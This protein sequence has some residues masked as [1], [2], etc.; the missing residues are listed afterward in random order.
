MPMSTAAREAFRR[1]IEE[2]P[3]S[4][5]L[6]PSPKSTRQQTTHNKFAEGMGGHVEEGWCSVLGTLRTAAHVRN[7]VERRGRCRSHGGADVEAG[8]CGGFQ[9][10]QSGK[11]RNDAR[12]AYQAGPAGER[13]WSFE[14]TECELMDFMHIFEHN[15]LCV[16]SPKGSGQL[17]VQG[18]VGRAAGI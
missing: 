16:T 2:T 10:L 3:G 18:L 6:F 7:Q 5:Y 11:V 1:Q 13:A 15:R 14:H 4:E 12:G 8:R 9:T 17:I